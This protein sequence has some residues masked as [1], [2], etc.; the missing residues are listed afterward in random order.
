ML[1]PIDFR[2][3]LVQVQAHD[4]GFWRAYTPR[5]LVLTD[6]LGFQASSTLGLSQFVATLARSTIYGLTPYVVTASRDGALG[7]TSSGA[8]FKLDDPTLGALRSRYDVV[9]LFGIDRIA[10]SPLGEGEHASLARFMEA[11]G[12]VFASGDHEDLGAALCATLP[13]VRAMRAWGA[14]EGSSGSK[15][16]RLTADLPD[17]EGMRADGGAALRPWQRLFP[18]YRSVAGGGC[19]PHP[20]LQRAP[21]G[22]IELF[23]DHPHA[24]ECRI[25]RDLTT[26]FSLD[27]AERDEWP[28]AVGGGARVSPECVALAVHRGNA[29]AGD[30]PYRAARASEPRGFLAITAYDGQRAGVGRVVTGATWH[31]FVDL[32]LDATGISLAA[33]HQ[34][35]PNA[36]STDLP[37]VEGLRQY[38]CNLATWLMPQSARRRLRFLRIFQEIARYPLIEELVVP[39][40]EAASS[41]EL[42]EIGRRLVAS[43]A[44]H[45][46]RFEADE[47]L[48][49]ALADAVGSAERARLSDIGDRFGRL[50]ARDLSLT[51]LGAQTIA[52]IAKLPSLGKLGDLDP[53][54]AF[55]P[56]ATDAARFG[57]RRY[58]ENARKELVELDD[59]LHQVVR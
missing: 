8:P 38:F 36:P 16:P 26:R 42:R 25:P 33:V 19:V 9:F 46:P 44:T 41:D 13:R 43:L 28:S 55:E 17:A 52:A 21:R 48:A 24:G 1:E 40:L 39:R 10:S 53:L 34:R 6:G 2:R 47:L 15:P 50:S 51:A 20:L 27:G 14:A 22:A 32:D 5:I 58:V 11:G 45:R 4:G 29:S 3:H 57:V 18:S 7:T 23:P 54:G 56:V 35:H 49:D 12:G 30:S 31:H 37:D 59:L